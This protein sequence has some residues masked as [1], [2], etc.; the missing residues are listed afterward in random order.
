MVRGM[1]VLGV[2]LLLLFCQM[3]KIINIFLNNLFSHP[4]ISAPLNHHLRSF[5]LKLC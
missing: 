2:N 3:N 1:A 5:L 4:Q